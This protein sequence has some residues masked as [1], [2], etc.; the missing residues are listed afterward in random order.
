MK[1]A[2]GT[3]VNGVKQMPN[4]KLALKSG[5]KITLADEDLQQLLCHGIVLDNHHADHP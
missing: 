3:F 1:A 2:N 5:D 4:Q